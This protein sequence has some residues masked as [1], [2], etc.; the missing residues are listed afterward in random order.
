[1]LSILLSKTS[2]QVSK[3][4]SFQSQIPTTFRI[5]PN[6][7]SQFCFDIESLLTADYFVIPSLC[8][9]PMYIKAHHRYNNFIAIKSAKDWYCLINAI[10]V[11][12]SIN[13]NF[14]YN[15]MNAIKSLGLS[16]PQIIAN[17]MNN[18]SIE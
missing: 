13:I 18:R 3:Y 12:M 5:D 6:N 11:S 10:T 2:P 8:I 4:N 16:R 17:P 14:R 15:N 7:V 9:K 1:M